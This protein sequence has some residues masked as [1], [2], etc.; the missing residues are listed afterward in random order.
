MRVLLINNEGMMMKSKTGTGDKEMTPRQEAHLRAVCAGRRAAAA[1]RR[2]AKPIPARYH[3]RTLLD[4]IKEMEA[5]QKTSKT[6][7][8]KKTGKSSKTTKVKK[9]IRQI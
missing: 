9:K 5:E 2:A 4:I 6:T 1:K 3:G 7:E 8:S